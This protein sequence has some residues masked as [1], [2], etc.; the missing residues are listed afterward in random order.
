MIQPTLQILGVGL[1]GTSTSSVLEKI[2]SAIK[3]EAKLVIFTPN[4]EFLVLASRDSSFKYLLNQ[5]DIN[6]PDGVGLLWASKFLKT[7]PLLKTRVA[8]VDLVKELF[9]KGQELGWKFGVV[10]NRRGDVKEAEEQIEKLRQEFPNLQI[11]N[12]EDG[13]KYDI[14]LACQGMELQERWIIE[15][16]DKV[17]A[18]V[19]I[20]VGGSLDLLSG[21]TKR[22]PNI[23]RKMGLEWL[24][25][26]VGNPKKHF[27]RVVNAVVVFPWLVLKER[28]KS[29][30]Y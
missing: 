24:W 30:K 20:G 26:L 11:A 18:K 23:V 22:A 4:P 15:N 2:E 3:N 28:I 5:A 13:K 17:N 10:G 21:F 8:G 19:F 7:Q 16:K 12:Y 6:I 29:N 25:R 9:V 27:G 14:V 1:N